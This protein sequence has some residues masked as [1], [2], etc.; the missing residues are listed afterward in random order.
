MSNLHSTRREFLRHLGAAGIV[1]LGAVPPS[2]MTRAAQAAGGIAA[3]DKRM[4]VLIQL[5]GGNDGLNTLV[6]F[7]DPAYEKARPGI[8]VNKGQVLKLN[9]DVGLH[10]SL[11]G[12]REL[13]DEGKLAIMQG[14]GYPNPDRSHFRSMDIW[15]SAQPQNENPRDGWL[16]RALEWQFDRQPALAEALSLGTD[17][18]PLAFVS[19]RVNVPTLR[20]LEEFQLV[21]G[22]GS[23]SNRALTRSAMKQLS[24]KSATGELDFLRR[25]TTTAL[26]SAER[27]KSLSST[28]R[29]TVSYPSTGLASRL[30]LIA[31]MLTAD[32]PA[33]MF[34]V[35]L[36]G[37]DTH[38]QQQPG[39]AA[40]MAELSGAIRAFEQ[41]LVEHKLSDRVMLATY[42][43]FGRRVA[44][45]GSLGTDHG[46]ASML[47]ALTPTGKAGLHGTHPSL[48]DLT[49]GDLKFNLD[50]RSVYATLLDK[51]LEIPSKGV[52]GGEFPTVGIV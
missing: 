44:E 52:L 34:V 43:E 23:A 20:R 37:F 4:L 50:F 29:T 19:T 45:N 46:A 35:S 1:S 9:N 8:G 30:K 14:V 47:F 6:P 39:H 24:A 26:T 5:A 36:D 22:Q 38:S 7:G 15:Q 2:F 3:R 16:G 27:L 18:L 49:D 48:T 25:A 13:Y 31:Q 33:R 41:D 10:P 12:L 11:T 42:S 17:K 32:L 28:Y 21:D 40:L 51:W